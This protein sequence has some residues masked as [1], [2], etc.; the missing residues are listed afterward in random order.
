M[1]IL[2]AL[3][4]FGILICLIWITVEWSTHREMTRNHADKLAYGNFQD[5]MREFGRHTWEPRTSHFP[6]SFFD[7]QTNSEIHA[8][9]VRFN[10]VGMLLSP[11][12]WFR[13]TRFLKANKIKHSPVEKKW[14][15]AA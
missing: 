7:R 10:G 11:L 9:I 1:V 8:S 2:A 13:V 14:S 15:S 12:G 3:M 4:L 6:D 5:F